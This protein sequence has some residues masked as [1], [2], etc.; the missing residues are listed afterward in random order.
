MIYFV[1]VLWWKDWIEGNI[2]LI[3]RMMVMISIFVLMGWVRKIIGLLCLI[4][5]VWWKYF[6]IIGFSMKVSNSGVGL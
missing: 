6:F 2:M 4:S 5:M 1:K 3:S